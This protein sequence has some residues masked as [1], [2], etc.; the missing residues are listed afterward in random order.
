MLS[1]SAA[2]S[3]ILPFLARPS[4]RS[5]HPVVRW[6]GP[7]RALGD[8]RDSTGTKLASIQDSYPRGAGRVVRRARPRTGL[9]SFQSSVIVS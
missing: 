4:W 7:D 8:C 2:F 3:K 1:R 9:T 6:H 5:R